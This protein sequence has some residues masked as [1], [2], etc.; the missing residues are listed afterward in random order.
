MADS[1]GINGGVNGGDEE[2]GDE[3]DGDE[4]DGDEEDDLL[5]NQVPRV[6]IARGW[7]SRTHC[8]GEH[9]HRQGERC[10]RREVGA[11]T[12][13]PTVSEEGGGKEKG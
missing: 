4:E 12:W 1:G 5:L 9:G 8:A 3:E 6:V 10:R 2:D 7:S 11:E 13:V